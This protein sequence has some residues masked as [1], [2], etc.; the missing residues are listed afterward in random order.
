[1]KKLKSYL[2]VLFKKIKEYAGKKEIRLLLIII[3]LAFL[4]RIYGITFGLPYLYNPD[5]P[6]FVDPAL[7]FGSGDF[8]PHWFGHPGSS[9]MYLLFLLYSA[10]FVIGF[11]LG[12]FP[13]IESFEQLYLTDP[14]T[15]YLIGRT[16]AVLFGT[17]TVFIVYLVAERIY[18]KK[19]GVIAALFLSVSLLHVIHSQFI[20]TDVPATFFIIIS[21]LFSLLILE[22]NQLKYYILAGIF[23]GFAIATKYTSG[24]IIFPIIIAHF[25]RE[26]KKVYEKE[27]KLLYF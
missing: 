1:M 15:F 16:T 8:N 26:G 3:F 12:I 23:G 18:A 4:L 21:F 6:A 9:L 7:S 5:E 19:V 20:R 14:T 11:L 13:N 24:I 25:L 27:N 10:Y 2:N 17:F 22:K